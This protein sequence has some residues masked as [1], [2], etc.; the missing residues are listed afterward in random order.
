MKKMSILLGLGFIIVTLC[1]LYLVRSGVSL[2]AQ[3]LIKPTEMSDDLHA[4]T[5]SVVL[6]LYPDFQK[7][8]YVLWGLPL[9]STE[10]KNSFDSIRN[11]YQKQ[12]K[13]TVQVINDFDQAT[14]LQIAEC[15]TPCWILGHSEKTNQLTE[16]KMIDL[17]LK[18]TQKSFMTLS[19]LSF[20]KVESVPDHCLSEKRLDLACL[21]FLSLKQVEK[22][23]TRNNRNFFLN[24][25]N[26]KD[27]FLFVQQK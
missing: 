15:Q 3:M 11:E 4:I 5:Q 9:D 22:K 17:K 16:N 23:M 12:S 25:Y 18:S 24:E 7:S 19:W 8:D 2:R 1:M 13:K 20:Q 6:R 26:E 27:L 10:A 14:A 21:K